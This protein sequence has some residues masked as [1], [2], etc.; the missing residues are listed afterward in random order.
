MLPHHIDDKFSVAVVVKMELSGYDILTPLANHFYEFKRMTGECRRLAFFGS[1]GTQDVKSLL[2][3]WS[4]CKTAGK[5]PTW[6]SLLGIL[7]ELGLKELSQQVASFL[8][9]TYV[10]TT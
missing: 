1:P 5:P 4:C 2:H 6:G 3:H 10:H 8:P 7:K 9:G